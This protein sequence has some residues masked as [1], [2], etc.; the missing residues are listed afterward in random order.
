MLNV[1]HLIQINAAL[2]AAEGFINR[3]RKPDYGETIDYK[4]YQFFL[5]AAADIYATIIEE[6]QGPDFEALRLYCHT[7]AEQATGTADH[8]RK[9]ELNKG[10]EYK[11]VNGTW[12]TPVV[13]PA[14]S[15]TP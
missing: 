13:P 10:N 2:A 12:P 6:A 7:L 15:P 8:Y 4:A 14:P 3:C 5:T 1:P 11:G 9:L